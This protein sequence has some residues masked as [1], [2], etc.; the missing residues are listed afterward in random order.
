MATQL[1]NKLREMTAH[2]KWHLVLTATETVKELLLRISLF[3]CLP[4][5][6]QDNT[7]LW[8]GQRISPFCD[9][10]K[11]LLLAPACQ[12]FNGGSRSW[13]QWD[14]ELIP[15][16]RLEEVW[17]QKQNLDGEP[18]VL[19]SILPYWMRPWFEMHHASCTP[20]LLCTQGLET[21][22]ANQ[23]VKKNYF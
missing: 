18:L 11:W 17:C 13:H 14:S 21:G 2:G 20:P 5:P 23:E 9:R 16:S 19:I 12:S 1:F 6:Q 8:K 10:T 15:I 7:V 3:A 22:F 4:T